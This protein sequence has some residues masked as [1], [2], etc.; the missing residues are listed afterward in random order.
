[1]S[2]IRQIAGL[3]ETPYFFPE[4]L[5]VRRKKQKNAPPKFI[6]ILAAR[7]LIYQNRI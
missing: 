3:S 2:P 6:P 1:M 5:R 4:D 7:F